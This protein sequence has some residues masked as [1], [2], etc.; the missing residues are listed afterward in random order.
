MVKLLILAVIPILAL[1][2]ELQFPTP[3]WS[4]SLPGNWGRLA[5][6]DTSRSPLF[7]VDRG[8]R[9]AAC[10]LHSGEY[11]TKYDLPR[12]GTSLNFGGDSARPCGF[13]LIGDVDDDGI[14]EFVVA[15]NRTISKYKLV[16]GSLAMTSVASIRLHPD[17]G[18]MWITD[19]CIGDITND[20]RNEIL[21]A[22]AKSK[23][24]S[25]GGDSW[26]AVLLFVCRWSG[27]SLV[28]M[29]NDQGTLNLELPPMDLPTE[30]MCTIADVRNIGT[31]KLILL[32]GTGDDV[33]PAVYRELVWKDGG[34]R[35]AGFFQL[36][37]GVL[38][39]EQWPGDLLRAATGCQFGQVNGKTA[40]L[41]DIVTRGCIWQGELFVFSGDSTIQHRVLWSDANLDLQSPSMGTLIDPDG[42]GVGALRLMNPWVGGRRFE[43][44]RL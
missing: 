25:A 21:I 3:T 41:A 1:C 8:D 26:S 18:R 22:A 38:Q 15:I 9:V 24:P 34:L 16:N 42:K 37:D 27:D 30:E 4:G 20:G 31:N 11:V 23:P 44:Y 2:G 19:G 28:Q 14:E 5:V 17:S 13:S 40:I 12:L 32:E 6:L 39:P 35:E 7:L 10:T 43:F 36:R 29:W 33:H